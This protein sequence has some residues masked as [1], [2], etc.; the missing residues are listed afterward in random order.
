[1]KPASRAYVD[2]PRVVSAPGTCRAESGKRGDPVSRGPQSKETGPHSRA[3]RP[4]L[5]CIR[6]NHRNV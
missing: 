3:A 6:R 2:T 1:M 4:L 5:L